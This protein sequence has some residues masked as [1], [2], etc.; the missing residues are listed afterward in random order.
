[1]PIPMLKPAEVLNKFQSLLSRLQSAAVL[2]RVATEIDR[3]KNDSDSG[4]GGDIG[5]RNEKSERARA[6]EIAVVALRRVF[7]HHQDQYPDDEDW[8][9][10]IWSRVSGLIRD[11]LSL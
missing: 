1:M 5:E 11:G 10:G 7:R 2:R 6:L 8:H 4:D 9:D 3:L